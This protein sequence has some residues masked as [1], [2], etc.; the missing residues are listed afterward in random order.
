NEERDAIGTL[1][2]V[3]PDAFR[4]W[5]I[6]GHSFDQGSDFAFTKAIEVDRCDVGSPHPR[7][8]ELWSIRYDQQHPE[9]LH[10]VYGPTKHF[11]ARR[12][13]PMHV[14]ENHQHRLGSRQR[15]QLRGKRLQRLL[16]PLLWV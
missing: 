14:L 7:R 10:P 1:D 8:L 2:D 11:E 16:P 6:S 5:P 4:Q 15:L 13:S 9:C 3:L 12:V